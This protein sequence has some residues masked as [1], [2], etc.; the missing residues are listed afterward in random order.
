MDLVRVG[1]K[2]IDRTRLHRLVDQALEMRAGGASQ[3]EVA[4]RLGTDRTFVSRLEAMGELRRGRRIAL[5]GFPVANKADL[6]RV[7]AEEGLDLVLLM[8]DAERWSFVRDRSGL[9]LVN[10]IMALI[11]QAR[12]LDAV[13][14][15][16]SDMRVKLMEAVLGRKVVGVVIGT[17]PIQGDRL[18]DPEE[19]RRL[20]RALKADQAARGE[21]R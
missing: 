5:V 12:E 4:D 14:F 21:E 10:E 3:Q 13:V 8:T 18:V 19:V 11:S 17:S 7:A 2:V 9:D 16:G 6:E 15:L 1:E 20:I